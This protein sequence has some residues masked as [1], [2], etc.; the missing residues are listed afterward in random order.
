MARKSLPPQMF[1]VA[2][3]GQQGRLTYE[4][5]IFAASLRHCTPG[6]KG[7]LLVAEPQPGPRWKEDPSIRHA[8][9]RTALTNLGAELVPFESHHFGS[10]YP[11]GNKIEMLQALPKGEP[12][13][14]FDTDTLIT[15]DLT[16]VPFDFD[17]P[18]ASLRP[19]V[20]LREV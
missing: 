3:V 4:A 19:L 1:N 5:L 11:Y 2:I 16:E 12:F 7:R 14:F 15:G 6:F 10:S 8:D 20:V 9:V 18:S 13:V 17:R